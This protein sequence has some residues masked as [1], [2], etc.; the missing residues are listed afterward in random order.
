[1]WI[2]TNTVIYDIKHEKHDFE[3]RTRKLVNQTRNA[4]T[5]A[6]YLIKKFIG[7]SYDI[8]FICSNTRIEANGAI[9]HIKSRKHDFE[10]RT[11]KLVSQIRNEDTIARYLIKKI[12]T[13]SYDI[14]FICL[15]T[16]FEANGTIY[17]I[18]S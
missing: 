3:S 14:K 4:H 16:R 8:K 15:N 12:I 1:M 11:S 9:Y 2:K 13:G 6:P 10:S 18:K 7:G 5:R 17:D